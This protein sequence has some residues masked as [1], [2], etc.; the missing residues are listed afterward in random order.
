MQE[1]SAANQCVTERE[2]ELVW[3]ERAAKG[4]PSLAFLDSGTNREETDRLR[5]RGTSTSLLHSKDAG[6]EE[7]Q[8]QRPFLVSAVSPSWLLV[9]TRKYGNWTSSE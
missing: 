2:R 7:R 6:G 1:I 4:S 3:K 9:C 5:L 8:K